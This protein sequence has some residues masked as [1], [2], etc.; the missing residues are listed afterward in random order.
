M[1]VLGDLLGALFHG[2]GE[3]EHRQA[4]LGGRGVP[5]ALERGGGDVECLV[6]VGGARHRCLRYPSLLCVIICAMSFA[7]IDG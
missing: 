5:P 4:A 7:E 2:V 1:L 3:A 6:N